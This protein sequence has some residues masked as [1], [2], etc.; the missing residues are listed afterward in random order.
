M[1][2][3]GQTAN[4]EQWQTLRA[5]AIDAL[6]KQQRANNTRVASGHPALSAAE[7]ADAAYDECRTEL[8]RIVTLSYRSAQQREQLN[9]ARPHHIANDKAS[10]PVDAWHAAWVVSGL[11]KPDGKHEQL[12]LPPRQPAANQQQ[13]VPPAPKAGQPPTQLPSNTLAIY[14]DGSG[15]GRHEVAA[16]WGFTVVTGGDGEAD[17]AATEVHSRCGHV[18]TDTQDARYLGAERATNNTAEL[19]AIAEALK[20]VTADQSGRPVLIRYDSL[21]GG[22][23]ENV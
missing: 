23:S 20:Y 11:A 21:Y 22:L 18:V 13:A 7:T 8:Q 3:D 17:T 10:R 16:G 12:I 5:I 14:T 6:L 4:D 15:P 1:R 19:T 2:P 9:L